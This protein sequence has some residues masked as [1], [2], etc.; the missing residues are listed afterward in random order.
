MRI[1][2]VCPRG[3]PPVRGGA[4]RLWESIVDEISARTEHDAELVAIDSPEHSF[5]QLVASYMAFDALDVSDYDLVITGKYPAWMVR[6]PRHV[7]YMAHPLRGL[8]EHYHGPES[9]PVVELH[10][11]TKRLFEALVRNKPGGPAARERVLN[12]AVEVVAALPDDHPDLAFP[13]P[14]IRRL[15]HWLDRD[16]LDPSNTTSHLAISAT[17]AA[18][19]GYFPESAV[20]EVVIPPSG[21][22]GLRP[23]P[24]SAVFT[25]SRLDGPKRIDLLIDSMAFVESDIELRI[26]GVGPGEANLRERAAGDGRIRFLGHITDRQLADEYAAAIVVPFVPLDEDL[27]LVTLEAQACGKP[28]VTC[29]DSGGA[30]ELVD[31]GVNGL[32]VAPEPAQVGRALQRLI[33]SPALAA[34]FGERGRARAA[35]VTWDRVIEALIRERPRPSRRGASRPMIVALSTYPADPP[36]H[37]G[38]VRLNRLL[39]ALAKHADV[40][41]LAMGSNDER[42]RTVDGLFTQAIAPPD[43]AYHHLNAK[44]T[45]AVGVPTG[46]IAATLAWRELGQLS[47]FATEAIAD[48]DATILAHPYLFPLARRADAKCIVYDAHNVESDLKRAMFASIPIGDCLARSVRELESA[49]VR[50]ADLVTAVSAADTERLREI[51]GVTMAEFHVVPNGS[52]V[53]KFSFVTGAARANER[54]NLLA[55]LQEHMPGSAF[56]SVALFLGSGHPPNIVA[57]ERIAG[58]AA[59]LP[60]TLFVLVGSHTAFLPGVP[61]APNVLARGE[62]D[63]VELRVLLRSC[64]VALNPMETG[65]GTNIKMLDYFAAGA[66]VVATAIGA[67]GLGAEADVHYVACRAG[68]LASTLKRTIADPTGCEARALA[69]LDLATAYDWD[70]LADRFAGHVLQMLR[71]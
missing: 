55:A 67:R 38:Q 10:P 56:T 11:A 36:R 20:V 14:L 25:A 46:D 39:R 65:A 40:H 7:V 35:T 17:V 42:P 31:D 52:D 23:G 51:A 50:A 30:T 16:A 57:A 68:D 62:V 64:D 3:V 8:Y 54:R 70:V 5:A 24:G 61:L 13:G 44:L 4:E 29:T 22:A 32:V 69:A 9:V 18:R 49:V 48:A 59:H 34:Q 58:A 60:N 27:G 66:P 19:P 33:D 21:L 43:D 26:A 45:R 6:H 2:M 47:R 53:S 71:R 37:G 12:G 1:A 15:V 28:V 63:D 41:L